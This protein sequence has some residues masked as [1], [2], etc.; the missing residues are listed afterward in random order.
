MRNIFLFLL[1]IL[2]QSVFAYTGA[3]SSATGE[4]GRASVD[5]TDS[6]YLNPASLAFMKGYFFTSGISSTNSANSNRGQNLTFALTDNLPDTVI[7]S[8]FA[9]TQTKNDFASNET[10]SRDFRLS[11]GNYISPKL[12]LGLGVNYRE[13]M[14]SEVRYKQLNMGMG[15][16]FA[17]RV[18]LGF[19][20]VAE[21]LLAPNGSL[22]GPVQLEPTTGLGFTHIYRKFVRTR[23]D[24]L[25]ETGNSWQRPTLS[26]GLESYMNRWTIIRI[27]AQRRN[28]QGVNAFSAGIGFSG[29]RF[30]VHYAYFTSPELE[31]LSR[32]SV[33]LAIPIW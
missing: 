12:A 31:S 17:P 4:T 3:V 1:L 7:P 8:S 9:Y 32:H 33:D 22:P 13:D 23:I 15:V 20:I 24:L 18:D 27:G 28:A 25:S 5:P 14:L 29:P 30:G 6:A 21:N 26:M 10:N 16:L 2:S 11:F 19:A